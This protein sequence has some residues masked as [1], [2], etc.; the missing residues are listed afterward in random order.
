MKKIYFLFCVLSV[1]LSVSAQTVP[2]GD[3]ENWRSSTAGGSLGHTA[4]TI[5]APAYWY[6]ADSLFISMGQL[7][8]SALLGTNDGDWR[9][10]L[11]QS[12]NTHGGN[13]SAM[14]LTTLQDTVLFPGILSN[15]KTHISI[16]GTAPYIG[17]ITYTDGMPMPSELRPTSVSAWVEY[18][19]GKDSLGVTGAD[20]GLLTVSALTNIHGYDSVIGRGI[21]PIPPG[22]S[23][24]QITAN[25]VYPPGDSLLVIDTVRINFTSS[26]G[27]ATR[28]LDSSML[29]VDDVTMA[30]IPQISH[31]GVKNVNSNNDLIKVYPNPAADILYF[32]GP[33]N[34]GLSCQLLSLNGRIVA[35]KTWTGNDALDI[36][37]V[38]SGLYFYTI[39]DQ[40]GSTIQR[41]KVAVN[42]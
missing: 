25:I 18:F 37:N 3:M 26:G 15:A 6:G 39:Y 40:S 12:S 36:S 29:Y 34:E 42:R 5:Q 2:G 41:G 13:Y 23:W 31:V 22:T 28:P 9:R 32:S 33:Q 20:T 17:P 10:Q 14:L 35:S 8:G 38:P 21:I 11:F 7:F 30:S 16:T 4:V 27:G 24:T 19:P 1:S